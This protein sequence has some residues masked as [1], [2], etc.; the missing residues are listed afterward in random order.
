MKKKVVTLAVAVVMATT[1]AVS[2]TACKPSVPEGFTPVVYQCTGLSRANQNVFKEMVDTYN[3]TQGQTDKVFVDAKYVTGDYNYDTDL[4]SS[5]VKYSVANVNA[6][7]MRE[8][9]T[10][11]A[12]GGFINLDPLL[13]DEVKTQFG[14]GNIPNDLV[15]C[16]RINSQTGENGKYLVGE[17][18]SLLGVPYGINPH[19]L[20][21]NTKIFDNWGIY[22][23]S[24]AE[25]ELAK[26]NT[27]NGASLAPHGYA[28]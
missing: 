22:T 5:S 10:A 12:K 15:N 25:D 14:Y 4:N 18:A 21:Y 2:L 19:V 17:G 9:M 8:L 27:D 11:T 7:Q 1:L 3:S 16:F 6:L 28:E 23:V 24:V 13:T 20:F 26:F